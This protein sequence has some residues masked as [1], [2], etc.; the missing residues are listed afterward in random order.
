MLSHHIEVPGAA[1]GLHGHGWPRE[2]M[3]KT[4]NTCGSSWS[5]EHTQ[6]SGCRVVSWAQTGPTSLEGIAQLGNTQGDTAHE[7]GRS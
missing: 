1:L 3:V 6:G 7:A 5:H 4:C 2:F